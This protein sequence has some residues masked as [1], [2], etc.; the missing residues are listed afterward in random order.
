MEQ[1]KKQIH[2][3]AKHHLLLLCVCPKENQA[4]YE[5]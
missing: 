2:L 1:E 4:E 3:T 5:G